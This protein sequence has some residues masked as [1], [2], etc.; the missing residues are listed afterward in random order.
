MLIALS[1]LLICFG[2]LNLLFESRE[3]DQIQEG[4]TDKP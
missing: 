3:N 1:F 4:G 2:S